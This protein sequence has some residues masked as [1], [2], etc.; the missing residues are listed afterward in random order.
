LLRK[1]LPTLGLT[2]FALGLHPSI[3]ASFQLFSQ[4]LTRHFF[5]FLPYT[6]VTTSSAN[7]FFIFSFTS[8]VFLSFRA[9]GR[10]CPLFKM[11]HHPCSVLFNRALGPRFFFRSFFFFGFRSDK[12]TTFLT[13]LPR[14]STAHPETAWPP[15]PLNH[16]VFFCPLLL[17]IP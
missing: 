12:V 8:P 10:W 14:F 2:I 1:Y 13:L 5:A 11:I 17:V 6:H 4:P 9:F 16:L 3:M 15:L 7:F